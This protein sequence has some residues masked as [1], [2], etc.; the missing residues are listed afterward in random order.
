MRL[1]QH[2]LQVRFINS[3]DDGGSILYISWQSDSS[4]KTK[5]RHKDIVFVTGSVPAVRMVVAGDGN[6]GIGINVPT[7]PLHV[8]GNIH[9]TGTIT[10]DGGFADYWL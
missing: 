1:T 8:V 9:N 3:D 10:T 4:V 2:L 5:L 7:S 6:V